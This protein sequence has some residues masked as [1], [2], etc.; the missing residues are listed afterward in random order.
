MPY[1]REP[2][3]KLIDH[4]E[5][6]RQLRYDKKTGH[7][8]RLV[9]SSNRVKVGD[10]AGTVSKAGYVQINVCGVLVYAHQL[11]HFYVTGKWPMVKVDHRNR[12]RHD[13]RWGN[14]RRISDIG[15]S[16]NRIVPAN[17]NGTGFIGVSFTRRYKLNQLAT[18]KFKAR[19]TTNG[20]VIQLGTFDTA[21]QASKAYMEAKRKL[22]TH[23]VH[24]KRSY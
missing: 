19:I 18:K 4:A 1:D 20:Q 14:I 8:V 16:E 6:R 3:A 23:Y 7:F 21:E 17:R 15:N 10:I 24:I 12:I 9:Q 13:N 22:H 5:L 2:K 11:A